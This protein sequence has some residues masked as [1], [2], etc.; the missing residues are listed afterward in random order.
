MNLE[1]MN[2]KYLLLA[3]ISMMAAVSCDL[4]LYPETSYNEGNV[5]V[6]SGSGSESQYTTRRDI[7][8]GWF[9]VD[10]VRTT[11]TAETRAP[12]SSWQ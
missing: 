11:H 2:R 8:T 6:E 7:S 5:N 4:D 3:S 10:A 1:I 12:E 9:T